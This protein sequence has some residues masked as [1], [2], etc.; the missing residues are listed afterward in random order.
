M[1]LSIIIST[2][3]RPSKLGSVLDSII[4]QTLPYKYFEILV[5]D[6]G[7]SDE[8]RQLI[9]SYLTAMP[10]LRFI[11]A[12][13]PGLHACRHKG[14]EEAV[15]DILVYADDDV[16]SFPTWLES[17]AETFED[18]DV[19]LVGGKISPKFESD[20]PK[21]ILNMWRPNKNGNRVCGYLSLLDLG[22]EK[23]EICTQHIFG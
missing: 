19:A 8:T 1:Q 9:D 18:K 4:K 17:I 7:S 13:D 22:N 16:E 23:S 10:N 14:L 3:N 21:C 6:N 20:P 12:N 5:V 2:K 11:F 15:K